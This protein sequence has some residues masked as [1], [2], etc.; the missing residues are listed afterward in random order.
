MSTARR[1]FAGTENPRQLRTVH[2]LFRRDLFREE[3]D[4]VAGVSN[5]PGLVADLRCLGLELPCKLTAVIDR[6]G[7][8]VRVGLYRL[9]ATDRRKVR[10][11]L[12]SRATPRLAPDL[13]FIRAQKRAAAK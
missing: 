3:I 6:D 8:R 4:A 13:T 11:W 2:E 9:T 7:R 10:R 5:G 1:K 12:A